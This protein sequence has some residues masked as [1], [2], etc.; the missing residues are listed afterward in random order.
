VRGDALEGTGSINRGALGVVEMGR[1]RGEED[2]G[3]KRSRAGPLLVA[4]VG[5][6]DL[7]HCEAE[8]AR[9]CKQY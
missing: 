7:G 6:A 9:Q 5:I 4:R 3:L 2:V 1:E 8:V